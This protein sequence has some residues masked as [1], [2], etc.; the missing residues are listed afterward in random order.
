MLSDSSGQLGWDQHMKRGNDTRICR[1]A[2][3]LPPLREVSSAR[4]NPAY[5]PSSCHNN[6]DV[7]PGCAI[8]SR[9]HVQ[10]G[11]KGNR[12]RFS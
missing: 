4:S 6:V 9:D 8:C 3:T 5:A 12:H 2:A 11:K 1:A 7:A 10:T